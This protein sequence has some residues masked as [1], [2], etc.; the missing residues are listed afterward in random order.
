MTNLQSC[1]TSGII[2]LLAGFKERLHLSSTL[3]TASWHIAFL[4]SKNCHAAD[5][6][7]S[8]SA[9]KKGISLSVSDSFVDSHRGTIGERD[10]FDTV[11]TADLQQ[12]YDPFK[13]R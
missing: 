4:R 12:T 3:S 6:F 5:I 13:L 9:G 8:P 7:F 2:L 1:L 11:G 10:L